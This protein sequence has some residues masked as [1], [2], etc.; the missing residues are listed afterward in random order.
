[1][2]NQKKTQDI[3][4]QVAE[5]NGVSPEEIKKDIEEAIQEMF[6]APAGSKEKER[7]LQMFP[8]GRIPT[9]YELIIKIAQKII[10][11]RS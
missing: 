3:F 10:E 9:S 2:K 8:D 1:M 5:Q 4:E 6:N 11:S 7:Q